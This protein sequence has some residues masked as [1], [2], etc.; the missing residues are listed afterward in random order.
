MTELSESRQRVLKQGGVRGASVVYVMSRDQRVRDNHALSIAWR[1]AKELDVPLVVVFCLY[2]KSGQ[3]AREHYQFMLEGLREV[4]SRLATLGVRFVMV[5]GEPVETLSRTLGHLNPSVVYFDFSPLKGVRL[6]QQRICGRLECEVRVVDAH[7]IVP[8]WVASDKLE[9]GAR[10]LRPKLHR[11]LQE[12]MDDVPMVIDQSGSP[13][14]EK[15]LSI[16]ELHLYIEGSLANVPSNGQK[17][18]FEP[19]ETAARRVLDEFLRLRLPFYADRRNDPTAD[20]LSGLSPYLHFGQL[21]AQ[22][23]ASEAYAAATVY[24]E[25][26]RHVDVLIEELVVRREL[27]DNYCYFVSSYT[28]LDGAPGWA[29]RTLE[30]HKT[31][32]RAYLYTREQFEAAKTHD[33][34]WNAAQRELRIEGK[35]HGYMRMYWAKKVLEWSVS[36][37]E[38]IRTLIYLN[39]FYSIDGG[40]PNGYTGILWAVA[41][42]HDRPWGE[43]PIYGTVRSMVY[44]GLKRKFMIS[45]YEQRWLS[46]RL[47]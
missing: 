15:A 3:R 47:D 37:E 42:V 40:D 25:L 9:V 19:G 4:E 21:S 20:G 26:E 33:P 36:P 23:I 12:Y 24:P 39:D 44:A 38:A 13:W 31:D 18:H 2:Q 43:R 41:G 6:V 1:R 17:L 11:R 14:P 35:M 22:K 29:Q 30:A 16:P 28:S 27:S 7:N 45:E 34:A 8:L 32:K 10:T 5:L 46:A